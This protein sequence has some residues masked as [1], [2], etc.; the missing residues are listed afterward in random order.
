MFVEQPLAPPGSAK[1][2]FPYPLAGIA[3]VNCIYKMDCHKYISF[4]LP[5]AA[6]LISLTTFYS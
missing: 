6:G 2:V 1:Y 4:W 5:T 3:C